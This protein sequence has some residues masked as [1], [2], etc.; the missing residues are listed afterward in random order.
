M[1]TK[2]KVI[3]NLESDLK[4]SSLDLST[5]KIENDNRIK[6]EQKEKKNSKNN[7]ESDTTQLEIAYLKCET[8]KMRKQVM[9]SNCGNNPK[10]KVLPCGHLF[11]DE[12]INDCVKSRRRECPICR[13]KFTNNEPFRV[14]LNDAAGDEDEME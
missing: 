8:E 11:C 5:L 13:R 14:F 9:C 6:Q 12:C 3:A 2:D 1:I 4:K 7:G 10:G